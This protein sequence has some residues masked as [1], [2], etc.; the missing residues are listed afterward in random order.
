MADLNAINLE[1]TGTSESAQSAVRST[2]E[3]LQGLKAMAAGLSG[4]Q[5]PSDSIKNIT[6][7][8]N[9]M[10]GIATAAAAFKSTG[11]GGFSG[12]NGFA[13]AVTDLANACKSLTDKDVLRLQTVANAMNAAVN[14]NNQPGGSAAAVQSLTD[15]VKA[16]KKSSG[17][18]RS[19]ASFGDIGK[20]IGAFAKKNIETIG[21][22]G[23]A[24]KRSS[25]FSIDFVRSLA[26]IAKYRILRTILSSITKGATEGMKNLARASS[27]ARAT[28]SQLSS[29]ALTLKNSMGGALYSV[30]ASVVGVL[31]SIISAAVNAMNWISMLFAILGGRATYQK[32]TSATKEYGDALG[33][34]AGGAKALKQELM[35]FD[36]IN[37][38]SPNSGGGGGGGGG[39][40]LDY[41]GMFEDTPIDESLAEMVEK[42][43]FTLL[44]ERLAEKIN[45]A[46]SNIDWNK[47]Q[48]GAE[49]VAK[50][51]ATFINGAVNGLDPS[52]I[53]SSIAGVVNTALGAVN[54]FVY[55]T[56]WKAL[57][58]KIKQFIKNAAKSISATDVGKM[59]A[60]K[61]HIILGTLSRLLP[62][63][64][65]EGL[66][67]GNA[68]SNVINAAIDT[69]IEA[70]LAAVIAGVIHSALGLITSLGEKNVLSNIADAVLGAI[71][72]ALGQITKEEIERAAKAALSELG[73]IVIELGEFVLDL[74]K[75]KIDLDSTVVDVIS[76][77]ALFTLVKKAFKSFNIK[78]YSVGKAFAIAGV[79]DALLDVAVSI[80]DL[81]AS[82][83][84]EAQ[85]VN[86]EQLMASIAKLLKKAG[87]AW[88]MFGGVTAGLITVGLGLALEL[89]VE[90]TA[91]TSDE[92]AIENAKE[93]VDD[94]KKALKK[95]YKKGGVDVEQEF[96]DAFSMPDLSDEAIR[97]VIDYYKEFDKYGFN[98]ATNAFRMDKGFE[99]ESDISQA[100]LDFAALQAAIEDFAL[101]GNELEQLKLSGIT[102]DASLAT[103]LKFMQSINTETVNTSDSIHQLSLAAQEVSDEEV[104]I[105]LPE[106]AD[107]TSTETSISDL[108]E[109]MKATG[110]DAE[111]LYTKIVE[112]P[113]DIV[114]N[115]ELNN[116]DAVMKDLDSLESKI[117][118]AGTE[119][120]SGF[121]AAFDGVGSWIS[122]NVATP[123]SNAF[124]VSLY[125][126][127]RKMMTTLKTGL[128]SISLPK[129]SITW[130][131]NTSYADVMGQQQAITI[132]APTI[133]FYARGGFPNAGEL[134]VANEAGPEMIGRI[135]NRPAV[136]NQEQIGDAIFKYMD[137]HGGNNNAIDPNA[138]AGAIVG[139]LKSAGMGAVYLDGRMLAN[140]I[141]KE[142]RR[143][144]KPAINY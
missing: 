41:G 76:N 84:E 129:F 46:L 102:D 103:F 60:A 136:A 6:A 63:N 32:A 117:T 29:G 42:A 62:A 119:G 87:F 97:S 90:S 53:G 107:V 88:V 61:L 112:I 95:A 64:A 141:N 2:A 21:K 14:A 133:K 38:I 143:S 19:S 93:R 127:G 43:D 66:A 116:Y 10:T 115:L 39:G 40:G 125:T 130:T 80:R 86:M 109:T 68:I 96:R 123:I 74:Q 75:I 1:I 45:N 99:Y 132:P 8:S 124:N 31:N 16:T 104:D 135:G 9:A 140:S 27:E 35:G 23:N 91:W 144:G 83:N 92:I 118:S 142:A 65:T 58:D 98:I 15:G 108:G 25:L 33:G 56:D 55:T 59:L 106:A 37:S 44:G 28:L 67:I 81:K 22:L 78:G 26:R 138:L 18:S 126:Y 79:I 7:I 11:N 100:L 120:V 82:E 5:I 47:I 50:S 131:N 139:A 71:T 49:K 51:I 89:K 128:K 121:K 114:Y 48:T 70:D 77:F 113:S 3:A 30:L 69:I 134:F 137:A 34:A 85:T 57:G 13:T 36:E 24:F 20:G 4:I 111:T 110:E 94:Y 12:L 72:D 101:Y 122:E 54:T 73:E 17:S 52:V 105:S